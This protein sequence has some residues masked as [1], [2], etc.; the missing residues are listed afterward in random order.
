MVRRDM[1]TALRNRSDMVNPL[2]FFVIV[3]S[4]FP[5]ALGADPNLLGRL[6]PSLI[7]VTATLAS[8][9]SLERIF[10][11]D[12]ED[13]SLEQLMLSPH[14]LA[15]LVFAKLTV[16]WL[17]TGVPLLVV[18]PLVAGLLSLPVELIAML[19][20]TLALGT[21]VLSAIG[22][23]GAA[24]TAGLARG[25]VLLPLLVLPL[26]VPTLIFATL[27][28]DVAASGLSP[29]AHLSLLGALA[30]GAMTLAPLATAAALRVNLGG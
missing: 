7:W 21:P 10:R 3:A 29:A 17:V 5:L 14:P 22:G 4:L 16:H 23:V 26:Y 8:M 11:H 1:T 12:L 27:A 6:A 25:G 28:L 20:V 2:L 9:L 24:L 30:L 18:A 15:W 19:V 13:G